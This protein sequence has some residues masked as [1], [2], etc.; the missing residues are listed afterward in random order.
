MADYKKKTI[1]KFL[2]FLRYT[3]RRPEATRPQ[4]HATICSVNIP[5][6]PAAV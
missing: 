2:S 1:K 6:Q 5:Q 3:N 4:E